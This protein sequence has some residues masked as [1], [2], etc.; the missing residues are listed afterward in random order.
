MRVLT[1]TENKYKYN[2]WDKAEMPEEYMAQAKM[3]IE[4]DNAQEKKEYEISYEPWDVF[5]KRYSR[6]FFKER[7]WI[8]K[9][10]PELLVHSNKVLEIGCG[11]GSTLIPLIKARLD[12]MNDY[13]QNSSSANNNEVKNGDGD[14]SA[15]I[16]DISD[17]DLLKCNNVYGMDYSQTAVGLLQSCIPRLASHFA[18]GDVTK[19]G[20]YFTFGGKV[21]DSVDIILLIYTLSAVHPSAYPSVFRL[22]HRT[23][24]AGG[25]VI[26]K[27]YYEM[28]LTQLRFKESQVLDKN[29]YVRGDDT[30]VYYFSRCEIEKQIEGLFRIVKYKEDRKLVINRKTQKEMYRCFI[31]IKLEK[32]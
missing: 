3:K 15:E 25:I 8:S 31:E 6:T 29:L 16:I 10:H 20:E 18:P 13:L 30:Y 9:E 28:D 4:R 11:T 19:V 22:M 26:F 32:L 27:D 1:E 7:Q 24:G 2:V 12:R 5:Y 21:L 14:E 17:S 23:L